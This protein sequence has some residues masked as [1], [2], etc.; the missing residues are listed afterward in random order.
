MKNVWV[1]NEG[2]PGHLSQSAGFARIIGELLP[3]QVH[4]IFGRTTLRGW[5]RHLLRY[6]MGKRGRPVPEK[7]LSGIANITIPEDAGRPDFIISSGGKSVFCAHFFASKYNVPYIFIGE[8]KPYPDPWFYKVLSPAEKEVGDNT[9]L[10]DLIPTPVSPDFISQKGN[11]EPNTWCMIIGG[12]SRS[13][14]FEN[15][16]WEDLARGMNQ[17]AE[18]GGKQWLLSTS[19][20]TG[21]DAEA[22][23]KKNLLAHTIKD[24][25]WWA[26]NP[27]R[28]LYSF[29]ARSERLFV[30]QDST[31]M[32]TEAISSGRPVVTVDFDCAQFS[33]GSYLPGYF[34][35]LVK[36]GYIESVPVSELGELAIQEES[37]AVS[38]VQKQLRT[39][40]T[41]I[42]AD[43]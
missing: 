20:R 37:G 43:L 8:R 19:R 22:I 15:K 2:S 3:I 29:I 25:V 32:V 28:E 12:K 35:R 38:S 17:L 4:E 16:D 27:R 7:W 5:Q 33:P 23:L 11:P 26:Q 34:K 31:T 39:I 42:I 6:W 1:I 13:Y 10:L 14:P 24:A 41:E 30:T 21:A 18:R 9:V 36:N 40:A